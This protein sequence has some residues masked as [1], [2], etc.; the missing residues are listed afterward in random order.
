MKVL[1]IGGTGFLGYHAA[2]E[3]VR[4]GHHVTAIARST[5]QHTLFP[6]TVSL[7]LADVNQ[8][9]DSELKRLLAGHDA[10]VY[11]AG[12]D[13]STPHPKPA[14]A[15]FYREN[16]LACTRLFTIA[17][18]VGVTRGVIL[19]SYFNTIDRLR[20]ELRLT[21]QHSYIRS[22]HIQAEEAL[23]AAMPDLQ[24]MILELPYIFGSMPGRT[25][26]WAALVNYVRSPYPLFFPSGGTN[27][28]SAVHVA[29]AIAGAIEY[30]VGGTRYPIGDENL[31]WVELLGRLSRLTGHPKRVITVPTPLVRYTL[32]LYQVILQV[33]SLESG[34]APFA[35]ADVQTS[36]AFFDP[37]PARAALKFGQGGLESALLATI[38]ASPKA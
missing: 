17:R 25:S 32:G 8:I 34:L 16:V 29:E 24:L 10:V 27:A 20:P 7:Q 33:R 3:C 31:T 38:Q 4:R 12:M 18:E 6:D 28:I 2:L 22:R 11:A 5:P 1:I 15:F 23:K 37:A 30:G 19:G 26:Q 36:N 35:Y 13:T 14:Y 21:E 9:T